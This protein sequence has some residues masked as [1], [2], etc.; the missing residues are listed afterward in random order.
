MGPSTV[1]IHTMLH[2]MERVH[3]YMKLHRQAPPS[4]KALPAEEGSFGK[5]VDGWGHDLRY[6]V[7]RDGAI[8][9]TSLGADGKPG[10]DGRNADIVLRYR[11]R[12]ADGTLNVDDDPWMHNEKF[13]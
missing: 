13:E 11:T 8:S 4:L 5:A 7:D 3:V 2:T 1:T 6:S 12:N 10:G 9:L